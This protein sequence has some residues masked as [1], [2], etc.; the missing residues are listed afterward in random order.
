MPSRSGRR[1]SNS[2][3]EDYRKGDAA[4]QLVGVAPA[5][6]VHVQ[7]QQHAFNFGTAVGTSNQ[8]V[9]QTPNQTGL[10]FQ[11]FVREHFNM[12][13]PGNSGKWSNTEFQ[14]DFV[15][16]NGVNNMIAFAKREGIRFRQHNML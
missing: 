13:V 14:R 4:L 2:N 3:I 16:M 6:D 7:L 8:Y 9:S 11:A 15:N 10:N 12:I 5:A 1:R